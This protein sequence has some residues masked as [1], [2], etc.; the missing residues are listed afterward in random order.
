[1]SAA[2]ISGI[3]Q[4]RPPQGKFRE[5]LFWLVDLVYACK[6]TEEPE[7]KEQ[8]SLV[9][10]ALAALGDYLETGNGEALG[11]ASAAIEQF[12]N[13]V[14]RFLS[15]TGHAGEGGAAGPKR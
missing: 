12:A 15:Q 6:S 13:V 2:K 3:L 5:Q 9:E 1:M 7:L 10:H 11:A 4:R 14:R 8:A